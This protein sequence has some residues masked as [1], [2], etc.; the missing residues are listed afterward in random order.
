MARGRRAVVIG[1][2]ISGLTTAVVLAGHY[3]RVTVV[4]RDRLPDGPGFRGGVPQSRHL[5]ALMGGGQRALDGLLPGFTEELYEAGAVPLRTTYDH[6]WLSPVGWCSRF[7]PP[8]HVVLS[9]TRELVEWVVRRRALRLPNVDIREDTQVQ[10]LVQGPGGE[11]AGVRIDGEAFSADLA[12]DASGRRSRT[13]QWLMALGYDEP[14]RTRV[15]SRPGYASRFYAMPADFADEWR[16]ISIQPGPGQPL[17][18]GALVPVEGG[19]WLVSLY[20]YL[21]D[22]PPTDEEGFLA[23]AASLRHPVLHDTIENARPVGPIH[24]FRHMA[25]ERHHYEALPR[26]PEGFLVVGDAACAVNPVYAQGMSM[27]AM[28]ARRLADVVGDE[29]CA[30]IQKEIAAGNERAWQVATGADLAY[31]GNG[32]EVDEEARRT[33]EYMQRLLE[34]AMVD[35]EVNKTFFDVMMMLAEPDVLSSPELVA[36][37]A[38]GPARP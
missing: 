31:L 30:T 23:F 37:V 16:V 12:V 18:G 26:W 8:S 11:V 13:P 19:R 33:G 38:Q 9:A 24:G 25:N 10:G 14:E 36:R 6:L 22:H 20:G 2:G 28:T 5:H 35:A 4:E 32:D 3:E 7:D 34:L 1:G 15:D 27:A 21:D 17:R 29:D